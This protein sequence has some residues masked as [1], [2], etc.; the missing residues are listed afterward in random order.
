[1][2]LNKIKDTCSMFELGQFDNSMY[3]RKFSKIDFKNF[4]LNQFKRLGISLPSNYSILYNCTSESNYKFLKKLGFKQ[5]SSYKG[6][7]RGI[8]V[9][10]LIWKSENN[11][12]FTKIKNYLY[13]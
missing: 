1:M 10:I 12:L 3:D 4:I 6:Y 9:K 13:S 2:R 8:D 7:S 5:I 11:S